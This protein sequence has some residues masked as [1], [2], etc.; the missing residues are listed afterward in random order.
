MTAET[1]IG[2]DV[3]KAF[4]DLWVLPEGRGQHRDYSR[5]ALPQLVQELSAL[6]SAQILV[7]ATGGLETA[8]VSELAAAG[9][10]AV[11]VNPRQVRDFA[12]ATGRRAKTDARDAA[13]RAQFGAILRPPV[14]PL[15]DAALREL[16]ALVTR[17]RQLITMQTQERNRRQQVSS[18]LVAAQMTTTCRLMTTWSCWEGKWPNWTRTSP[19]CSKT[20]S[21]GEPEPI[22]CAPSPAWGRSW[23]PH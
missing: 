16:R 7:E 8:L 18:E 23:S 17:R 15:P 1:I 14:R 20:T 2:I 19:R 5:A 13:T 3:S 10:P 9:L 12:K 6:Q 11:V 4:L 22:C 21:S